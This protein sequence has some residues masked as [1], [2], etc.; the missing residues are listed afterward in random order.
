[1]PEERPARRIL[2][3]DDDEALREVLATALSG[4]GRE[5][6]GASDGTVALALLEQQPYDLVLSD[7]RMPCVDGPTL[8]ETLRTRH[9]FP[10]RFA[11]KLP[12][13]IFMTGN[14]SEHTEFLRG[15]TD[16]ILEKPF[17]LRVI[18]QMVT[19]L[20]AASS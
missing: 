9:H 10:V 11:T 20:L 5:I 6:D 18:R 17:P 15:T 2:I 1:M 14:A 13:V 12:R 19:V 3:V 8:Y 4:E 7:L 16:P